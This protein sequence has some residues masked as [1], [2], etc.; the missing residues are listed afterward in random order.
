MDKKK[1]TI[2]NSR[3]LQE[4]HKSKLKASIIKRFPGRTVQFGKDKNGDITIDPGEPIKIVKAPR[5]NANNFKFS[6]STS[7]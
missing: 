3:I 1:F 7:S 2:V 4:Q 5:K 6:N